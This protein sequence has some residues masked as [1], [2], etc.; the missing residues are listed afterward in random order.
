MK[1]FWPRAFFQKLM[2]ATVRGK[3]TF[4]FLFLSLAPILAIGI[5]AYTSS[6]TSLEGEIA[7]KL[8][9]VADNKAY[10]LTAWFKAHLADA[11]SLSA[12]QAVKDLVSPTFRVVYPNLAAKTD[13]ERTQRVKD[14]IVARQETNPSYVDVLIVNGEGKVLVSSSRILPQEGK[15]LSELGLA[16]PIEK[17]IAHVTPVFLSPV[18]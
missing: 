9:A 17:E 11:G 2:P 1:R 8:D 16:K 15:N 7:N 10:I 4:W 14:L 5:I 13:A 18:A 12:S 6:R 3:L